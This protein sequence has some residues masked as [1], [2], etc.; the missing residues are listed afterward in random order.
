MLFTQVFSAT[1]E[2]NARIHMPGAAYYLAAV[3]LL[4]AMI[5]AMFVANAHKTREAAAAQQT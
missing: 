1:I 4:A 2:K 5:L 3:L